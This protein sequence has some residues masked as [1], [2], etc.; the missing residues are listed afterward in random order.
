MGA[1]IRDVGEWN[2]GQPEQMNERAFFSESGLDITP[3]GGGPHPTRQAG[4]EPPNSAL[5]G[6]KSEPEER[7]TGQVRALSPDVRASYRPN[8]PATVVEQCFGFERAE[9]ADAVG[10][11]WRSGLEAQRPAEGTGW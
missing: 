8:H 9:L 11:G 10:R 7:D 2:N 1:R 5:W 6:P 4:S 3:G